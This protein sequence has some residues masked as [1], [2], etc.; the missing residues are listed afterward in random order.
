VNELNEIAMHVDKMMENSLADH[1][2]DVD[3]PTLHLPKMDEMHM[4]PVYNEAS[5]ASAGSPSHMTSMS[6][7]NRKFTRTREFDFRYQILS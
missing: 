1:G 2:V 3:L 5:I 4:A 7:P 6:S